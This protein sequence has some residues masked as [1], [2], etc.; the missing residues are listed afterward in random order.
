[1]WLIVLPL[2]TFEY[3]MNYLTKTLLPILLGFGIIISG[4]V[5]FG[6][7]IEMDFQCK[8]K[9]YLTADYFA[10]KEDWDKI[11][12]EKIINKEKYKLTK[13]E[14]NWRYK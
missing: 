5:I 9:I 10:T 13:I 3:P 11:I 1:M 4:V 8:D 12:K 6:N 2:F 14:T 7:L